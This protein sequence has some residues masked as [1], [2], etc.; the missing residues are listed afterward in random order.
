VPK[1]L[2]SFKS[3]PSEDLL[4][5]YAFRRLAEEQ[6]APL[7][8]HLLACSS[9][10]EA[11]AEIDEYLL[12]MKRGTAQ[13][14]VSPVRERRRAWWHIWTP[15]FVTKWAPAFE[16]KWAQSWAWTAAGALA[17]LVAAI[18]LS[19]RPLEPIAP[20]PIALVSLRGGE[21]ITAPRGAPLELQL[22]AGDSSSPANSRIEIVTVA[23]KRVW[24]GEAKLKPSTSGGGLAN[25]KL[26]AEVRPGLGKGLYWVRLYESEQLR[27]ETGLRVQ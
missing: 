23:G 4:E 7:E 1:G 24:N 20:V 14:A 19:H 11:L 21:T 27:S 25:G 8:E 12:L 9:C 26:E 3:H 15:A 5:E 6:V 13:M 16:T 10:Q 22:D 2:L 17:C 18:F